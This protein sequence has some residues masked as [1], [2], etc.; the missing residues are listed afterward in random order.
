MA[1]ENSIL[2]KRYW[3]VT[4]FV[5]FTGVILANNVAHNALS[6]TNDKQIIQ[7]TGDLQVQVQKVISKIGSWSN[8]LNEIQAFYNASNFVDAQEFP[9]FVSTISIGRNYE[10]TFGWIAEEDLAS[11]TP[12]YLYPPGEIELAEY[13]EA[14]IIRKLKQIREHTAANPHQHPVISAVRVINGEPVLILFKTVEKKDPMADGVLGV[15]FSITP[16]KECKTLNSF[17]ND[18]SVNVSIYGILEPGLDPVLLYAAGN[19]HI[20]DFE[21]AQ[22]SQSI[23]LGSRTFIVNVEKRIDMVEF[24]SNQNAIIILII[25]LIITAFMALFVVITAKRAVMQKQVVD[26]A[27]Q[28]SHFKSEFLANMSHELRTPLNSMIGMVQLMDPKTLDPEAKE[29]FDMIEVSSY[30]LLEIVNDILDLSKIEAGQ[31]DLEHIGFDAIQKV[32]HTVNSMRHLASSKGLTLNYQSTDTSLLVMGDPL[33][34]SRVCMN[35]VSNAVR[36]TEKGHIDVH[37][38]V[39]KISPERT[40]IKC[41]VT[42]TGVGIAEDKIDTIF[43]KFTQADTSTTRK[44][45]GTGL[46]LTITKELVSLMNGKIGVESVQGQGSTFWFE[47]EFET[48]DE[49]KPVAGMSAVM[50]IQNSRDAKPLEAVNIL[51]AEDHT[52]NQA[53]MKKLFRNYGIENYTLVENGADALDAVNEGNF[54]LVL[55]DCH[56]PEMNGYDATIAIRNLPDKV[57]AGIPI[58]AMTAN[59]MQKDEEKCLSIDMNAY[60]SKPIDIST[61]E[62]KLSPWVAFKDPE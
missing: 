10:A 33:R 14:I 31:V 46:G 50:D 7:A 43:E 60:M 62:S 15:L 48:T 30:T 59:A 55:M 24:W 42:D 27:E 23:L 54:D 28:A 56:M 61:F 19:A 13:L 40:L 18:E 20:K 34:F 35:L 38:D 5:L 44:F 39:K 16:L 1:L 2:F 41:A 52:M 17:L 47:I 6:S 53:F 3:I 26:Q 9:E 21:K 45:G 4:A 57:K 49:I 8:T 37:V 51:I 22:A 25:G 32:R 36:Y 12:T 29:T 58:I 11:K